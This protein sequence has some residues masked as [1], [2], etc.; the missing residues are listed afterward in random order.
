MEP[1]LA[2]FSVDNSLTQSSREY[3]EPEERTVYPTPPK[4]VGTVPFS[5][6]VGLFEKL[7]T[8]RKPERRQKLLDTW[9]NV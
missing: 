9:F 7:Q 1:S 3:V 4:N 8:E 5:V 2:P 6:L